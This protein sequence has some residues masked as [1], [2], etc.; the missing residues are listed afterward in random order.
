M[1]PTLVLVILTGSN[2]RNDC[3]L[4]VTCHLR[5]VLCCLHHQLT[6][7]TVLGTKTISANTKRKTIHM[8]LA[9]K[10]TTVQLRNDIATRIGVVTQAQE[11]K[12]ANI[13]LHITRP[14][15]PLAGDHQNDIRHEIEQVIHH[16]LGTVHLMCLNSNVILHTL[17]CLILAHYQ[18]GCQILKLHVTDLHTTDAVA[19]LTTL[20]HTLLQ[21]LAEIRHLVITSLN[22]IGRN[23]AN[24]TLDTNPGIDALLVMRENIKKVIQIAL[25][26]R[27]ERTLLIPVCNLAGHDQLRIRRLA[28]SSRIN[29]DIVKLKLWTVNSLVEHPLVA[30]RTRTRQVRH[31]MHHNLETTLLQQTNCTDSVL[32]V[33]TTVNLPQNSIIVVLH[34][35]LNTSDTP[36]AV[37][38]QSIRSNVVRTSLN[39]QTN[40]AEHSRLVLVNLLLKSLGRT[41]ITIS[42]CCPIELEHNL[43]AILL[44]IA[45]PGAT[46]QNHLHLLA[47]LVRSINIARVR[48]GLDT[49]PKLSTN[50]KVVLESTKHRW[51]VRQIRPRLSR[52]ASQ[53][54]LQRA[55]E[56]II[57]AT[58]LV[59]RKSNG[60][61][62]NTGLRTHGALN[63]PAL[64]ILRNRN[65]L[66]ELV[67][68][69]ANVGLGRRNLVLPLELLGNIIKLVIVDIQVVGNEILH[70]LL[71]VVRR[72]RNIACMTTILKVVIMI[73]NLDTHIGGTGSNRFNIC[74]VARARHTHIIKGKSIIFSIFLLMLINQKIR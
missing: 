20:L 17:R 25:C 34:T 2:P 28:D 40:N 41:V 53:I 33:A 4:G 49:V 66:E 6:I 50:I 64:G 44:R 73:L 56:A 60:S 1:I 32:G 61:H 21:N 62:K 23:V 5:N 29:L 58:E 11:T 69:P 38:A 19:L 67:I 8:D 72:R 45:L 7:T 42:I 43:L 3:R 31:Q 39:R 13:R 14:I 71:N 70:K 30:L 52:L 48:I 22:S 55:V 18:A 65:M 74:D 59:R 46:R 35:N 27:N 15:T 57:L 10:S 9:D 16:E 51:L 63:H 26:V 24:Q 36:T 12:H 68:S 54:S 37:I 47:V